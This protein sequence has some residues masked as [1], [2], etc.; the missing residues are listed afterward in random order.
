LRP[1][2]RLAQPDLTIARR[3]KGQKELAWAN[4]LIRSAEGKLL[5]AS[6]IL[7][8]LGFKSDFSHVGMPIPERVMSGSLRSL[9]KP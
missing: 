6:K 4:D 5:A 7:R 2:L 8:D 1:E 3:K 9:P